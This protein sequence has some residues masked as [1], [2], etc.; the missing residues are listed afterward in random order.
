VAKY[1]LDANCYV[2][3]ARTPEALQ[4]L[5]RFASW[6]TP[7]LFLSAVVAA[8]LRAGLRSVAE[9]RRLERE[10]L[11]PFVRRNRIVTPSAAAWDALGLTLATLGG[12]GGHEPGRATQSFAFDVLLA[13]S[14]RERGAVL[15]TRNRRDMERIRTVFAFEFLAPYPAPPTVP[16]GQGAA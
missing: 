5:N 10:V 2:D 16:S 1:V 12:R 9:R 6:A 3:A 11:A 15:I 13:Y 4:A 14:C 8:E 7:Q